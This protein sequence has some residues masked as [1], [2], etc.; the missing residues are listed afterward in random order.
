MVESTDEMIGKSHICTEV[1]AA[2]MSNCLW[3]CGQKTE[4][5]VFLSFP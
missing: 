4:K 2:V 5:L 3:W 1:M